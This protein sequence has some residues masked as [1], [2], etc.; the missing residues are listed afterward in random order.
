MITGSPGSGKTTLFK[1]LVHDLRHFNPSGF[2]TSEIRKGGTRTGFSLKSLDG[3]SG[4]LAHVEFQTG[5]RV[6]KYRVDLEGFES[7]KSIIATIAQKGGGLIA[8]LKSR[9]DVRL[10]ILTRENQEDLFEK[11]CSILSELE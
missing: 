1:R 8:E 10:F 2:Y 9:P 11:I 4:I 6:G 5:Y 3:R 7:P